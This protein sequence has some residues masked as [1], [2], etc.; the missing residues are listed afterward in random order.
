[1]PEF[2]AMQM[3]HWLK[4][5]LT[6][7]RRLGPLETQLL[8]A[9]W[10]RGDATVR[11]LVSENAIEGAYTT[12]MTTLDRLHK[13]GLLDRVLDGR[14]FRYRPRQTE[15][16]F[17]RGTFANNLEK[18]LGS[19]RDTSAPLSFLVDTITRHDARLLEE[20]ERVVDRKRQELRKRKR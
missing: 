20:L 16:E 9:L 5:S 10:Q 11:E 17:Y 4:S 15:N 3:L 6:G 14:A 8:R 12:V 18:L 7:G 2:E 13:K 1:M 19:A